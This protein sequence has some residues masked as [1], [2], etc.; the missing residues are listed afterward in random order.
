[1]LDV[2]TF[3]CRLNALESEAV[4]TRALA[5]GLEL[6]RVTRPGGAV[7]ACVWDMTPGHTPLGPLWEAARELDPDVE[8]ELLALR[9]SSFQSEDLL[10]GV[11]AF[12]QKRTPSWKGRWG[13][14]SRRC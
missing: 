5:A 9:A 7:A 4:R 13:S 6:A 3:G 8:R 10:E 1:M 2:I 14:G 12:T 11:S